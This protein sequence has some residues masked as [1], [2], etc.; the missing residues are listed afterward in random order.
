MRF[1]NQAGA[2]GIFLN[3]GLEEGLSEAAAWLRC[4]CMLLQGQG[5]VSSCRITQLEDKPHLG[6]GGNGRRRQ[7]EKR[8]RRG[9]KRFLKPPFMV[10]SITSS[11]IRETVTVSKVSEHKAWNAAYSKFL[12]VCPAKR[13]LQVR[14]T[15]RAKTSSVTQARNGQTCRRTNHAKQWSSRNM[16]IECHN[17]AGRLSGGM[18]A[19]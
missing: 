13:M 5:L 19:A 10:A 7:E 16:M 15:Y 6:V 18:V 8:W 2:I 3:A 1:F 12:E 11:Q 17:S 9:T 4:R 14:E